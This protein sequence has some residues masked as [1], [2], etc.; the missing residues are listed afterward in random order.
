MEI[1]LNINALGW[2][3]KGG[4]TKLALIHDLDLTNTAPGESNEVLVSE[5]ENTNPPYLTVVY[6]QP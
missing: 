5:S 4:L 6:S 3:V 2:I 1:P